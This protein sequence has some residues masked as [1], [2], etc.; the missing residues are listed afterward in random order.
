MRTLST[1]YQMLL[2]SIRLTWCWTHSVMSPAM[3]LLKA[4]AVSFTD[5]SGRNIVKLIWSPQEAAHIVSSSSIKLYYCSFIL[6]LYQSVLFS[7]SSFII[8]FFSDLNHS[9]S[10]LSSHNLLIPFH[11]GYSILPFCHPVPV[12]N[13]PLVT[14]FEYFNSQSFCHPFHWLKSPEQ[15]PI[16][17]YFLYPIVYLAHSNSLFFDPPILNYC[18]F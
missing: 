6:R 12:Y 9:V 7:W 11:S 18:Y 5:W 13:M 1:N 8:L 2:D 16:S 3:K 4:L 15:V 14:L 10:P 17:H